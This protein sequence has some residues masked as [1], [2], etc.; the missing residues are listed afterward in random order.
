MYSTTIY[1]Q[2][3]D[4]MLRTVDIQGLGKHSAEIEIAPI[5]T[6]E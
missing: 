6:E 3:D 1:N 5:T 4:K 2:G